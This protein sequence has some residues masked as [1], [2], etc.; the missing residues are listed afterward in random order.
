[1]VMI[2]RDLKINGIQH[3][4][5]FAWFVF[6]ETELLGYVYAQCSIIKTVQCCLSNIL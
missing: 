5:I 6:Y 2:A 1:M 4:I 3:R